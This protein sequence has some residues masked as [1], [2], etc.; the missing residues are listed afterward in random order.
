MFLLF[1]LNYITHTHTR[2]DHGEG[3]VNSLIDQQLIL[4]PLGSDMTMSK[5]GLST[6]QQLHPSQD[7][8]ILNTRL[9]MLQI[10]GLQVSDITNNTVQVLSV[11]LNRRKLWLFL[12]F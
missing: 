5:S 6:T 7:E 10:S 2:L 3:A 1:N 9:V 8:N 4:I 11:I 12:L